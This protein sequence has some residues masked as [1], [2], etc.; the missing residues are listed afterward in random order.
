MNNLSESLAAAY[1]CHQEVKQLCSMAKAIECDLPKLC[2][3]EAAA[4]RQ[5]KLNTGSE[6]SVGLNKYVTLRH[7]KSPSEKCRTEVR[8][9]QIQR[10]FMEK[11]ATNAEKVQ[12]CLEAI[13]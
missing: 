5:A 7:K 2:I 12:N 6:V 9:R 1:E 11:K 10:L 3:L 8:T 13:Q 4:N